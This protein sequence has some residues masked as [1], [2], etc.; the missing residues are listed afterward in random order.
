MKKII[1][2]F[3]TLLSLT[4][5]LNDFLDLKPVSE[6]YSAIYWQSEAQAQTALTSI[7]ADMQK[8]FNPN[9]GL[10][11][12]AWYEMRSDNFYGNPTAGTYTFDQININNLYTTHPSADWN[13]WYKSI[14]TANTALYFIPGIPKLSD[15]SRNKLLAE[16][17]FLRAYCYFNVVRIWGNA[18]IITKP[19]RGF[20][21]VTRP[22]RDSCK[23]IMDSVIMK[24][25]YQ[26]MKL[27][28]VSQTDLYRFNAGAI[29][30]L[31]TDV[32]MWNHNYALADSCSNILINN[33]T[34]KARYSL[35]S[36]ANFYTVVSTATTSENIWT[37]KWSFVNNGFNAIVESL[38]SSYVLVSK[39]VK[40]MWGSTPWSLDARRTQT[41]DISVVYGGN[42]LTSINGNASMW[43]YQ[44]VTRIP[45][46]SNEKYI[47]LYRLADIILLRAEALNKLGRYA[48]ALT[49]LNKI[50]TRA[51][52]PSRL[53]TDYSAAPDK[54]YAIESDI[55]LERRFELLGEGKRWFD[56][57]R[58]GRAMTTMNNYFENYLKPGGVTNYKPFTDIWQ[59]YWPVYQNNI[60]ENGN[61]KQTGQY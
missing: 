56:L 21:D 12:I 39:E 8:N 47:P 45:T 6:T 41:I 29:Y 38:S 13:M 27:V 3:L 2:L 20:E 19:V 35:V 30:A 33:A 53:I 26:S 4:S 9:R 44:P 36:T 17:Y 15:L 11:Y 42:Y 48:E 34:Y 54:T 32:A 18:P 16:A 49:E 23:L 46:S 31:A 40:D 58:T 1:F 52:L 43:K 37:L 22:A 7:Y 60:L 51:G 59:L 25:L 14:G 55:L 24:D 28:D 61:L 5:C 10:N 57:M 50:R